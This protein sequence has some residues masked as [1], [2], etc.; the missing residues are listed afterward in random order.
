MNTLRE[1]G[2]FIGIP[3]G[4]LDVARFGGPPTTSLSMAS[5]LVTKRKSLSMQAIIQALQNLTPITLEAQIVGSRSG[6]EPFQ[7]VIRL[8]ASGGITWFTFIDFPEIL[9]EPK[10]LGTAGGDFTPTNLGPGIFQCVVRRTGISNIGFVSLNKTLGAITVS[11]RPQPTPTPLPPPPKPSTAKFHF[12]VI[13]QSGGHFRIAGVTWTVWH[14]TVSG[15]TLLSTVDGESVT[16]PPTTNGQ[17]HVHADVAA[18]RL[19]TGLN[20]L[21]EFRSTA[22]GPGGA[23]TLVIVLDGTDQ[24][25]TFRLVTESQTGDT[26]G[27]LLTIHNPVVEL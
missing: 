13:N 22:T 8:N 18:T 2:E 1:I 7:P 10:N 21:A 3:Q 4:S 15:F 9:F 5:V 12:A 24:S 11:A 27:S 23:V 16:L 26:G 19:E 6:E 20:E 25:R 14:Q 17:Y